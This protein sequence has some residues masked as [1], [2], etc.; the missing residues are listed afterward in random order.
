[1]FALVQSVI[2]TLVLSWAMWTVFGKMTPI[3]QARAQ[4]RFALLL[5]RPD[6]PRP[7]NHLGL[8]ML[9]RVADHCGSGCSSCGAC[10]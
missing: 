1:M 7:L 2:L 8:R 9:P 10:R 4:Q 6:M 3:L 5:M